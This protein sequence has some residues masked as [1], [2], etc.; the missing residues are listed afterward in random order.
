MTMTDIK[1]TGWIRRPVLVASAVA[2]ALCITTFITMGG[3]TARSTAHL[4]TPALLP[5]DSG[6]AQLP[7]MTQILS[8]PA[9]L[10]TGKDGPGPY[11]AGRY[12]MIGSL[13]QGF[14]LGSAVSRFGTLTSRPALPLPL[15]VAFA[16]RHPGPAEV[17]D[18]VWAFS[19][20][21]APVKLLHDPVF[22]DT[23]TPG[24]TALRSGAVHGGL[25][26]KVVSAAN[27]GMSEFRFEWASGNHLIGVS[28]IGSALTIGQASAVARQAGS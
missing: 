10:W 16:Q 15:P 4:P 26:W 8:E 3:A 22:T 6:F 20:T 12:G 14:V 27:G 18:L 17:F 11:Q 5:A 13:G 25:A 28:V 2:G 9:P 7:H 24:V 23:D 21:W 1:K 19:N